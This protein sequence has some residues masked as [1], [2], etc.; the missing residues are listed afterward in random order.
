MIC[1]R[2]Q[3]YEIPTKN[4]LPNWCWRVRE[5]GATSSFIWIFLL[6]MEITMRWSS[7]YSSVRFLPTPQV[8]LYRRWIH[9]ERSSSPLAVAVPRSTACGASKN[10]DDF[11]NEVIQSKATAA[12]SV[13]NGNNNRNHDSIPRSGSA[14]WRSMDWHA[15][16]M[17]EMQPPTP[18]PVDTV[19]IRDRLV[20]IKRDD[21][22]RG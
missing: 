2:Y 3:L 4:G 16:P 13:D 11:L 14:G 17:H 22:V 8:S 21:Q 19:V 5:L 18:S 15:E 7:A 12:P 6:V 10:F 9:P 1:S 20:Y